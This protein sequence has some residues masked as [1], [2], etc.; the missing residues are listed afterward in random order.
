MNV[1]SETQT[2]KELV[3]LHLESNSYT[4][5]RDSV[6]Q[7]FSKC[8][9]VNSAVTQIYITN[10]QTS[11]DAHMSENILGDLFIHRMLKPL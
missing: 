10:V 3:W 4:E 9:P 5:R 6:H 1:L 11:D 2:C 8:N 7:G